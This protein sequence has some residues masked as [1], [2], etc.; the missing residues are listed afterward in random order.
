MS[1]AEHDTLP[2]LW[3][4]LS[5]AR[6]CYDPRLLTAAE[7]ALLQW[8]ETQLVGS[9]TAGDGQPDT[10]G[11]RAELLH[12]IR[13]WPGT[14]PDAFA[15][16]LPADI[17][18]QE[19]DGN[20]PFVVDT[21]SGPVTVGEVMSSPAVTLQDWMP[22]ADATRVLVDSGFTG[23][24]VVDD[25]GLLIGIVTEADLLRDGMSGTTDGGEGRPSTVADVM[26]REVE[27]LPAT[28]RTADAA[29][30]MLRDHIRCVPIRDGRRVVGVLTRRDLLRAGI[31]SPRHPAD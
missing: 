6:S 20:A 13:D 25:D 31:P 2:D 11:V 15:A 4:A 29:G 16:T 14:D 23:A 19:S 21:P 10:S 27:S 12:R 8:Y 26:T 28:A 3:R 9:P 24:P 7:N 22:I 30:L 17:R 1:I 5:E 18:L